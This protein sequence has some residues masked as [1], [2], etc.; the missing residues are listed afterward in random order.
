MS[1]SFSHV[2]TWLSPM[3]WPPVSMRVVLGTYTSSSTFSVELWKIVAVSHC[4]GH[5][6]S[7]RKGSIT[8]AP[9]S[10]PAL[11]TPSLLVA[12]SL[13]T[14][15]Q[16]GITEWAQVLGSD[17]HHSSSASSFQDEVVLRVSNL[18]IDKSPKWFYKYILLSTLGYNIYFPLFSHPYP[19]ATKSG[20]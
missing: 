13:E 14:G 4:L 8:F 3:A 6:G 12:S 11:V 20:Q 17:G 1:P 10:I 19:T 16:L 5:P 9:Q 18:E 15:W 7:N 2:L